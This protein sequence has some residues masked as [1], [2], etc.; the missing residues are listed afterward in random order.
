MIKGYDTKNLVLRNTSPNDL[1]LAIPKQRR[2]IPY[3]ISN[4]CERCAL[5]SLVHSLGMLPIIE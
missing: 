2:I 3:E 4:Q 5:S 1:V